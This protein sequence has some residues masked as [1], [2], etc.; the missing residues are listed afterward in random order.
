MKRLKAI[1]L[2]M[3][4]LTSVGIQRMWAQEDGAKKTLSNVS[5]ETEALFTRLMPKGDSTFVKFPKS[6]DNFAKQLSLHFNALDW[7]LT[8]PGIGIEYDLNRSEKNNKS[9][10]LFAKGNW[11]TNH[12]VNPRLQFNMGALR[13]EFRKYWR[14]GSIGKE[15]KNY[16]GENYKFP[17]LRA[18]DVAVTYRDSITYHER[19][20]VY[21][22]VR[23][24]FYV[25]GKAKKGYPDMF[26][27]PLSE[28]F[29]ADSATY[30]KH[31]E[32]NG[33][34]SKGTVYN[35]YQA[36]RRNVTSGRTIREPR[37]WR[38]YY[39]GAYAGWDKYDILTN[40]KGMK[41]QGLYAGLTLGWSIPLLT[42]EFPN[43][44]GLD[45]ELGANIGAKVVK[46]DAYHSVTNY[47]TKTKQ[48]TREY[49]ADPA[50]S[51][52]SWAFVKAPVVQ[53]LRLSLVYRFRNISKKISLALVDDYAKKAEAMASESRDNMAKQRA[54]RDSLQTVR[55]ASNRR[56]KVAADS[57]TYWNQ[58]HKRRL[59]NAKRINP[60]TVFSGK[61]DTLYLKIF[62]GVDLEHMNEREL[63]KFHD[64]I[65]T[66]K[67]IAL[68]IQQKQQDSIDAVKRVA[69]KK[70]K[71]DSLVSAK[72]AKKQQDSID[73]AKRVADKKAKTDS[74]VNA[75]LAK[76]QQDSIE[77]AQRVADKKAEAEAKVAD[78]KKDAEEKVA[79]PEEAVAD[80]K[81]AEEAVDEKKKK[82]QEAVEEKKK[83]AEE[84][85]QQDKQAAEEKK[86][87]AELKKQQ[88]AE[89]KK[90]QAEEK[91]AKAEADKKAKEEAKAAKS[92]K[93][94]SKTEE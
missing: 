2:S 63:G 4:L 28:S 68:K 84:K 21:D 80:K 5:P 50:D 77:A 46:Y 74:L 33:D 86:K 31:Q 92:K 59:E 56:A 69:E 30:K 3:L 20:E 22:T 72:L 25:S 15:T 29:Y 38:A 57:A 55:S 9:L 66:A 49:V 73:A 91:K 42:R 83:Q 70:A 13:L 7:A 32:F 76:K 88:A 64:S 16:P 65:N 51:K 85:K 12:K 26:F 24:K 67:K 54:L 14:T 34:P 87:Q 61:D 53:E 47:D 45:L 11:K 17:R 35:M 43:E 94:E 19:D 71:T 39:M 10:L 75:K 36:F 52:T 41:G 81:K 1:T 93:D 44:G 79:K 27:D 23:Y 82:A 48:V 58:W 78:K 90:K 60:D 6:K 62:R 8:M 89:E 18:K 40:K 37:N